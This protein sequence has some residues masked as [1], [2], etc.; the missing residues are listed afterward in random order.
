M[1]LAHVEIGVDELRNRKALWLVRGVS[2]LGERKAAVVGQNLL[3]ALRD[4]PRIATPLACHGR[5][6]SLLG[7]F[8]PLF[9]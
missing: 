2:E 5:T 1:V 7:S 3:P 8:S 4:W 9:T 6:E